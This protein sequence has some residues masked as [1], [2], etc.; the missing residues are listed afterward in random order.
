MIKCSAEFGSHV[1]RLL[2]M[3][4]TEQLFEAILASFSNLHVTCTLPAVTCS[5]LQLR[6]VVLA[7]LACHSVTCEYAST[8]TCEYRFLQV[9]CHTLLALHLR[10][11]HVALVDPRSPANRGWDPHPHPRRNRGWGWGWGSGVPCPDL[12]SIHNVTRGRCCRS[13]LSGAL[14]ITVWLS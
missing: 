5:Y 13:S 2:G 4:G 3:Q 10:Q 8:T 12:P 6:V 9:S 7:L 1:A 11:L 14:R